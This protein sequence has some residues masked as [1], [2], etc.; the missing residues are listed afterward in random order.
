[1]AMHD[2]YPTFLGMR[3][4]NNDKVGDN[5]DTSLA[6]GRATLFVGRGAIEAEGGQQLTAA[7]QASVVWR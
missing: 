7:R 2:A 1:M 4:G 5:G 6:G 3:S